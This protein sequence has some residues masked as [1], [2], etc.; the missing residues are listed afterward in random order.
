M[1]KQFKKIQDRELWGSSRDCS[2]LRN[3]HDYIG[4]LECLDQ[5]VAV[6]STGRTD[7]RNFFRLEGDAWTGQRGEGQARFCICVGGDLE[8]DACVQRLTGSLASRI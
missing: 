4:A 2:R 3:R 7:G 6:S 1:S 5:I 8:E